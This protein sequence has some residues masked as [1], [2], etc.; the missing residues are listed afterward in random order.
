[1]ALPVGRPQRQTRDATSGAGDDNPGCRSV[2]CLSRRLTRSPL[3]ST[4]TVV[5]RVTR[6]QATRDEARHSRG[7]P[8]VLVVR[9]VGVPLAPVVAGRTRDVPGGS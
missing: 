1:M 8:R 3:Q 4:T 7:K 2:C 9:A 5:V 6:R